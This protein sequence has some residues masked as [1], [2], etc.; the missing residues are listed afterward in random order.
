MTSSLKGRSTWFAGLAVALPLAVMAGWIGYHVFVVIHGSS[1]E[2]KIR[3]Y[4]P[5][6]LLAG[7]YLQFQIDFE[8][9][10][11]GADDNNRRVCVCF[12]DPEA[13]PATIGW[14]G[15]C[16]DRPIECGSYIAG[17]CRGRR[18]DTSLE[19]FYIPDTSAS[20]L[21]VVPS[22]ASIV[23]SLD[24]RGSGVVTEMKISGQPLQDWLQ[25]QP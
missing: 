19:R 18:L 17:Y 13:V 7:H 16:V 3:G 15:D 9:E 2:L 6:D 23:V 25:Q 12:A 22:D 14:T 10:M 24:G 5:R 4:D 1:V 8:R 20:K 21:Q 11:C